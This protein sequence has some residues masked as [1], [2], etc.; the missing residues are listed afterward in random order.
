MLA[1][2]WATHHFRPYPYG[3]WFTAHVSAPVR[4]PSLPGCSFSNSRSRLR[5]VILRIRFHAHYPGLVREGFD[6]LRQRINSDGHAVGSMTEQRAAQ[7][8]AERPARTTKLP[9]VLAGGIFELGGR[10][11]FIAAALRPPQPDL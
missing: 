1:L 4:P 10:K 2:V 6:P 8:M 3:R 7:G 5:D 11:G 9:A